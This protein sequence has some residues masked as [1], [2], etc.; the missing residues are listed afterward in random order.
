[1]RIKHM[2][3]ILIAVSLPL[4]GSTAQ[5]KHRHHSHHKISHTVSVGSSCALDNNGRTSCQG[6]VETRQRSRQAVSSDGAMLPHPSGCPRVAFCACGASVRVFGKSIR[7][8]WPARAWYRF[9]RT[10]PASGMVAVRAHHVFVLESQVDG[11]E[12]LISDYNSGGHQSRRHVRSIAGYTIVNPHAS[13]S[14]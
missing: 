12:W 9:P 5:A 10:S 4:V 3:A 8:L 1:M 6:A 11:S 7:S 2:A 14:L 13:A